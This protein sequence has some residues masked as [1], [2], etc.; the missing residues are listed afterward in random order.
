VPL[1]H[2]L[3]HP[4]AFSPLLQIRQQLE[5]AGLDPASVQLFS[6]CLADLRDRLRQDEEKERASKQEKAAARIGKLVIGFWERLLVILTMVYR[7]QGQGMVPD[8]SSD[9]RLVVAK[10]VERPRSFVKRGR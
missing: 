2:M 8:D 1:C 10:W 4:N 9:F 7:M 5:V 6:E 3:S